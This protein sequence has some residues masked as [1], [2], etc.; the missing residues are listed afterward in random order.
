MRSTFQCHECG[1]V[2]A[3]PERRCSDNHIP[4]KTFSLQN[5]DAVGV[6]ETAK[7]TEQLVDR[8]EEVFGSEGYLASVAHGASSSVFQA[9]V[10]PIL[11]SNGFS[12]EIGHSVADA[13]FKPD[14]VKNTEQYSIMVE[15]ERGKTLDN[16]M[17]M[18][19][20]WKCHIHPSTRHLI[21]MVPIWYEKQGNS[22]SCTSTFSRVC[23]RMAPF[24]AEG[25]E[26]NVHSLH[27]IGY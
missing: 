16:N 18:L 24:F 27:I 12:S 17:D 9:L 20:M 19:D 11:A 25:N 1:Q 14:F 15:V 7:I 23:R 26:T 5:A 6:I 8:I 13:S 2:V 22:P 10:E 3:H 21:L 4:L